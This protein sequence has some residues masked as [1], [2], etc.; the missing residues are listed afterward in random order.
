MGR[1]TAAA[2]VNLSVSPDLKGGMDA[3]SRSHA[4]NWSAM[5]HPVFEAEVTVLER[6]RG[7]R[8]D[9]VQR[10]RASRAQ[11][12]RQQLINGRNGGREWVENDADYEALKRLKK[13]TPTYQ[14]AWD[15]PWEQ[16]RCAVDP[17][18]EFTDDHAS[19]HFFGEGNEDYR[20]RPYYVS[21]FLAGALETWGELE[22]EVECEPSPMNCAP[23]D[24]GDALAL[25]ADSPEPSA[26]CA[27]RAEQATP[28]TDQFPVSGRRDAVTL[29]LAAVT[30]APAPPA[31]NPPPRVR[32]TLSIVRAVM[33][34][35]TTAR[36]WLARERPID[37]GS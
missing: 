20:E 7:D 22:R 5:V 11:A 36:E 28:V 30:E 16:L 27:V 1:K 15:R 24:P 13:N 29:A 31:D 23:D 10:L 21:A 17:L 35:Y 26:H 37:Y 19:A 14:S 9:A 3:V 25:M 4:V 33:D 18:A 8:S 6:S 32:P 2:R 12:E 34:T